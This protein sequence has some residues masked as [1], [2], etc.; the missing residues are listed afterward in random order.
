MF[1][2]KKIGIYSMLII[3][4]FMGME[5]YADS[6]ISTEVKCKDGEFLVDGKCKSCSKDE[7]LTYK[8]CSDKTPICTPCPENAHCNGKT[9]YCDIGYNT[10]FRTKYK[11]DC[12]GI[13]SCQ[14]DTCP[15]CNGSLYYHPQN[16][17]ECLDCPENA[18]C[19]G[20]SVTYCSSGYRMV[21]IGGRIQCVDTFAP[22][23]SAKKRCAENEY[24][25]PEYTSNKCMACPRHGICNGTEVVRCEKG[26]EKMSCDEAVGCIGHH[27]KC[28]PNEFLK[29]GHICWPCPEHATCDGVYAHCNSGYMNIVRS[30]YGGI[31]VE[32]PD[33]QQ[34]QQVE[35]Q[36][37]RNK[38]M[39]S[40]RSY[41]YGKYR[42]RGLK[43]KTL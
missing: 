4:L 38:Q 37:Y 19:D 32:D 2:L 17:C 10:R 9:G 12:S 39:K 22:E 40:Q 34:P 23:A 6:N 13:F 27:E 42:N 36:Q 20:V 1:Y 14:K 28:L 29:C 26:Y 3:S 16:S 35:K 43:R 25:S 18:E 33:A 7:Y 8:D 11:D 21:T 41:P 31:C 30:P 24:Y 15:E 5:I